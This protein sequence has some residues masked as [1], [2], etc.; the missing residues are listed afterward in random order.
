MTRIKGL[1]D[2][3]PKGAP[4]KNLYNSSFSAARLRSC[5]LL[6]QAFRCRRL[7]GIH[8][9]LQDPKVGGKH[10]VTSQWGLAAKV[11][12]GVA[13]VLEVDKKAAPV[14]FQLLLLHERE[15]RPVKIYPP[16]VRRLGCAGYNRLFRFVENA[17]LRLVDLWKERIH[18]NRL[19]E[20]SGLNYA[21][22]AKRIDHVRISCNALRRSLLVKHRVHGGE[23]AAMLI[24]TNAP[25]QQQAQ[26]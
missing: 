8:S 16:K 12:I 21:M 5:G 25:D 6:L 7:A 10:H 2:G 22:P 20:V 18:R 19:E 24:V 14:A 23:H 26:Q 3:A 4:F 13:Q 1:C 17:I 15:N 9:L 11:R